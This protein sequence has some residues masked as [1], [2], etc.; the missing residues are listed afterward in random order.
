[1]TKAL[2]DIDKYRLLIVF[3][4][5]NWGGVQRNMPMDIL[6]GFFKSLR[7]LMATVRSSWR[8]GYLLQKALEP[9]NKAL[10]PYVKEKEGGSLQGITR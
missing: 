3:V 5:Y 9:S 8:Y 2:D 10:C 4:R 1:M 7:S 6:L